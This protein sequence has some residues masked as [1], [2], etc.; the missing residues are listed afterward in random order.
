MMT[1]ENP[2]GRYQILH[3]LGRG[4]IGT[5][6]AARSTDAVVALKTLDPALFNQPDANFAELFLKDARSAG[7]LR[8]RNIVKIHDAGEAGGTV[9]VAMDLLEGES[10]RSMLD[11]RPLSIARA[12]QIF[13]DIACA[14][15]Y[16]H[17][18]G[19][20]HR[21]VKPSNIIVLR[22][23]VAKISD[24][25]IGQLGEAALLSG[26]RGGCLSYMS[27]EQVRGDPVDHRCDIFSLGAVF[28]EMLTRRAPFEGNSPKEIMEKIL[29]AEP[30][31]PSE[32]NPH[33]PRVLDGMVL[34]MLAGRPDDRLPNVGI[35][36]RDLQRLEEGL[37]LGP[38]ASA[39]T[40]EPT[41]SVPSAGAEPRLRTPSANR[42]RDRE[43]MHEASRFPPRGQTE[44]AAPKPAT[45]PEPRPRTPDPNRFRDRAPMQDAPR[46]ARHGEARDASGLH[47]PPHSSAAEEF[48][49]R[50]R[51]PGGE[52][53]DGHDARF[54]KDREPERERS[55]GSRAGIIAAL[56][57][58]LA[59]LA[60][61]LTVILYYSPGPS[62]RRTAA[63]RIHEAP[64]TAAAPSP[65]TAPPPVAEA[66]KEPATA[67]AAPEASPPPAVGD[68]RAEQQ[69]LGIASAPNPLPPKPLAAEPSPTAP[70][71]VAEAPKERATAP[72]APEA[73]PPPAVGDARAEQQSLGIAS[74]ANPLPPKP[75]AAEPSPSAQTERLVARAP[76][77]P[78]AAGIAPA[79]EVPR[80][81][82]PTANVPE[83]QPG[84]TARLI[85]AVS[86]QGELYIDGKH[87]G[88]TPPITTLDLEPGIHRIEI[89]SGSRKPYL[90]YMTVEAGDVR[91][92]RHD[93]G[94]KPS[95]PPT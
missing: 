11:E 72:A 82:Q 43:V 21:G 88:T 48:Q 32:V 31:L 85:I 59:V 33:V 36:L 58:M 90:T 60:I 13:D 30:P 10:L 79:Q 84:G 95:G 16:A 57:L 25:G 94:A 50:S 17:E 2:L 74:A 77:Q 54:T 7:R 46:F 8:H 83:R 73:S 18:E 66:T 75:L 93:F 80:V 91:R 52:A 5:V 9:Y 20:V 89:R 35:L 14:L 12:I 53:F 87:Y 28:Y 39:G 70:P 27:P 26:Q 49:H 65:S 23:G 4:A 41:A 92:I 34:C 69:S 64:A 6:Y 81:T 61:G 78:A 51:I 76:E 44:P 56:A 40:A 68:A 24:F 71:L 15:A 3:E 86:P 38:G 29:H 37:G 47:F 19:V 55:S 22:S 63:S 45:E 1:R 42:S 67:P 62:E